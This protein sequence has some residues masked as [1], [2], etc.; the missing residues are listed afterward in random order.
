M[1]TPNKASL[2]GVKKQSGEGFPCTALWLELNFDFYLNT[3]NASELIRV[4]RPAGFPAILSYQCFPRLSPADG[5]NRRHLA[6][7]LHP[8]H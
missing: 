5:R 6:D 8:S 4:F 3:G 7:R 2:Q 1:E